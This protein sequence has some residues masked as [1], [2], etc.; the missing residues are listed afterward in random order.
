MSEQQRVQIFEKS[1]RVQIM[2]LQQFPIAANYHGVGSLDIRNKILVQDPIQK[3]GPYVL[4]L[5]EDRNNKNFERKG[6]TTYSEIIDCH[7]A[8]DKIPFRRFY[9]VGN[10][11]EI[12]NEIKE[13]GYSF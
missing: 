12:F 1:Q 2:D 6:L 5:K 3:I 10:P 9:F 11:L 13:K 8:G 7:V 4:N